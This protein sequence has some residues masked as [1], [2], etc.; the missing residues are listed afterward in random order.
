MS[1]QTP[2]GPR[3][4]APA[5]SHDQ[6]AVVWMPANTT[7]PPPLLDS[8]RKRDIH[9]TMTYSGLLTMAHACSAHMDQSRKVGT[10]IVLCEPTKLPAVAETCLAIKRYAT[11]AK[12]W[13]FDPKGK[14]SLRAVTDQDLVN[15]GA[16]APDATSTEGVLD[17]YGA[18]GVRSIGTTAA[19]GLK[20]AGS[21]AK[22]KLA[23][24]KSIGQ[25]TPDPDDETLSAEELR[26]LLGRDKK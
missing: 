8:L 23:G 25:V 14:Q 9:V 2:F 18:R 13:L 12:L 4:A 6:R 24:E 7:A 11:R 20:L 15:W 1:T 5:S 21:D 16:V 17:A 10:L 19:F 3:A 26:M 22:P